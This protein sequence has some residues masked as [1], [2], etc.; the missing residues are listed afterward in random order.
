[1]G[2]LRVSLHSDHE[3][4]LTEKERETFRRYCD[5]VKAYHIGDGDRFFLY[6]TFDDMGYLT[7][8]KTWMRTAEKD[9]RILYDKCDSL[10][11][12]RPKMYFEIEEVKAR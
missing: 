11:G 2:Y 5:K 3:R 10:S 1:M 7:Y 12:K 8:L 6:Q 4:Y 9:L